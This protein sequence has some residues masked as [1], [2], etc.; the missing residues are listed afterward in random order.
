MLLTIS[1]VFSPLLTPNKFGLQKVGEDLRCLDG[2]FQGD[3]RSLRQVIRAAGRRGPF[4]DR[5]ERDALFI[6]H[7]PDRMG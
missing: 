7:P 2:F 6:A 5:Q 1:H 3:T 4:V